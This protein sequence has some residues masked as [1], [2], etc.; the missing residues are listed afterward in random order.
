MGEIMMWSVAVE[1]RATK[2]VNQGKCLELKFPV[3]YD[4][5]ERVLLLKEAQ[6]DENVAKNCYN[7]TGS[8]L[9]ARVDMYIRYL[10]QNGLQALKNL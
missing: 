1:E 5:T 10:F 6:Y 8:E 4:Q 9:K 7:S 3:G 2:F